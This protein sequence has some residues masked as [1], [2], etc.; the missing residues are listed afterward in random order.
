VL[1]PDAAV[2]D[3]D[4]H[5]LAIDPAV[6]WTTVDGEAHELRA[7][8]SVRVPHLVLEDPDDALLQLD[9]VDLR[10]REHRRIAVQGI[11]VVMELPGGGDAALTQRLVMLCAQE[12]PILADCRA[13]EVHL[14]ARRRL[15]GCEAALTAVVRGD[16]VRGHHDDVR[17]GRLGRRDGCRRQG[18]CQRHGGRDREES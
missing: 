7:A 11:R 9:L 8:V 16:G 15:C 18:H 17:F 3:A 12:R 10:W 5:V 6:V 13:P 2:D 1:G 4:H 14:P